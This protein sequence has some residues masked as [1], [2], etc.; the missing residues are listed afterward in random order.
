MD[1][2]YEKDAAERQAT[3]TEEEKVKDREEVELKRAK[4]IIDRNRKKAERKK[5]K[6]EKVDRDKKKQQKKKKT[7]DAEDED[8]DDVPISTKRTIKDKTR[9]G[10]DSEGKDKARRASGRSAAFTSDP[11]SDFI[12]L[13]WHRR[14]VGD[15]GSGGGG[16][17]KDK[18]GLVKEEKKGLVKID[19]KKDASALSES[20]LLLLFPSIFCSLTDCLSLSLF[21]SLSL[22]LSSR[23]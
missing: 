15:D 17:P 5:K 14:N 11:D 19:L 13:H 16:S 10:S 9:G 3:M 20:I 21:F 12:N 22:I 23:W 8:E 4:Q 1:E 2:K 7:G 6:E 18:R